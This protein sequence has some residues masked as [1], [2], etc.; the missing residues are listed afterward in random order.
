M[1]MVYWDEMGPLVK[2]VIPVLDVL[3]SGEVK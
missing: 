3:G 1:L 2:C